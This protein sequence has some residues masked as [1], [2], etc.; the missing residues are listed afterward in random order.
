MSNAIRDLKL[1]AE[2]PYHGK[3]PK[4]WAER[5]ALGVLCDLCGR[6]GI[7]HELAAVDED[8]R[9]EIVDSLVAIIR[10]AKR[11]SDTA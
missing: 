4:D 8:V 11:I 1:G 10:D 6:R 3:P 9:A 5:A 2:Y 7:K